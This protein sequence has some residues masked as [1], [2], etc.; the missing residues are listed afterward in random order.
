M[1]NNDRPSCFGHHHRW[2]PN[3]R[4]CLWRVSCKEDSGD[5]DDDLPCDNEDSDYMKG[6]LDAV[7]KVVDADKHGR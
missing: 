6:V 3:C 5:S 4:K 7:Q 2:S 1:G